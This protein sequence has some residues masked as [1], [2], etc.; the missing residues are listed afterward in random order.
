MTAWAR[1]CR[2]D[3]ASAAGFRPRAESP[4]RA[5]R[6]DIRRHK[7]TCQMALCPCKAV[8]VGNG[9]GFAQAPARPA[10]T[11]CSGTAA[12]AT[13]GRARPRRWPGPVRRHVAGEGRGTAQRATASEASMRPLRSVRSRR[14]SPG[15]LWL[16]IEGAMQYTS[17]PST[18]WAAGTG[19]WC[20]GGDRGLH[21]ARRR[22]QQADCRRGA[23]PHRPPAPPRLS[24]EQ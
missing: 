7:A 24:Q 15:P 12:P 16:P 1:Q 17:R 4:A 8:S 6:A 18:A 23:L 19:V 11:G 22:L 3:R 5:Q 9:A 10:R 13:A 21:P 20:V 2:G 14:M